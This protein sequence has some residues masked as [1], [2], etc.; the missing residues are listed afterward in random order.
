[1]PYVT[2]GFRG[3]AV[4]AGVNIVV[5]STIAFL[6]HKEKLATKRESH[7]S[8]V[9]DTSES[10]TPSEIVDEKGGATAGVFAVEPA[11][12]EASGRGM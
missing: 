12:V 6:A 11:I 2:P 4:V 5:F 1:M 10:Q 8:N 7:L 9:S 3:A